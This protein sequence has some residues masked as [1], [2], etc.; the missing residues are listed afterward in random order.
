MGAYAG[1]F[2]GFFRS[3]KD[4]EHLDRRTMNHNNFRAYKILDDGYTS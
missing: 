3:V 2:A 4:L 1:L